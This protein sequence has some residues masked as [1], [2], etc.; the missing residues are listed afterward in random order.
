M[1]F[2]SR[3]VI[4]IPFPGPLNIRQ[5]HGFATGQIETG[6]C[7]KLEQTFVHPSGLVQSFITSIVADLATL[8]DS[9]HNWL[10]VSPFEIRATV[11][12]YRNSIEK[13][14]GQLSA[15]GCERTGHGVCCPYCNNGRLCFSLVLC[16]CLELIK[17]GTCSQVSKSSNCY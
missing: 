16:F 15:L 3:K 14:A 1:A 7:D 8:F 10:I 2:S 12:L 13:C 17:I 6:F 11:W 5:E 4:V 9:F